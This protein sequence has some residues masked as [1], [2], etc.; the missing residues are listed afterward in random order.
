M[1]PKVLVRVTPGIKTLKP[2]GPDNYE[3]ISEVRV[4]LVKGEFKGNLSINDKVDKESCTLVLDQKS[5]MGN[6]VAEI[7]MKMLPNEDGK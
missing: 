4:G 3:A 5:K 2:Q 7:G 1:D 6:V